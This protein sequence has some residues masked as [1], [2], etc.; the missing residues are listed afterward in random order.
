MNNYALFFAYG[1]KQ[2]RLVDLQIL[3][4]HTLWHCIVMCESA[5]VDLGNLGVLLS[6]C[7][8]SH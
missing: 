8:I 2:Q 3:Q 5:I 4:A 1:N 7:H 6:I